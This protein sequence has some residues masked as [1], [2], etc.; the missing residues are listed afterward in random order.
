M[1][2]VW[3]EVNPQTKSTAPVACPRPSMRSAMLPA[4]LDVCVI[5]MKGPTTGTYSP[6]SGL[7]CWGWF[8]VWVGPA[9]T[10]KEIKYSD[11]NVTAPATMAPVRG[12]WTGWYPRGMGSPVRQSVMV[13]GAPLGGGS[14]SSPAEGSCGCRERTGAGCVGPGCAARGG[15]GS[16]GGAWAGI[17]CPG[18]TPSP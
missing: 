6:D 9:A 17:A 2:S 10:N 13:C 4:V 16:G 12:R 15:A 7:L 5:A 1:S 11:P 3:G 14:N 8:A 18:A